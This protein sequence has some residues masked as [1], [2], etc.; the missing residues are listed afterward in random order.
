[1][2]NNAEVGVKGKWRTGSER[3]EEHGDEVR[4]EAER[5]RR[6]SRKEGRRGGGG[7]WWGA[8]VRTVALLF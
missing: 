1:M 3:T 6:Q 7:W 8:A 5:K 4:S 2:H